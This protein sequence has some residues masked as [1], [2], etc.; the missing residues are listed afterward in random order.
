M[1]VIDV[2]DEGLRGKPLLLLLV[3]EEPVNVDAHFSN[4]A[5]ASLVHVK[6]LRLG[7]VFCALDFVKL[8]SVLLVRSLVPLT[9]VVCE[10]VFQK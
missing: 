3:G 5:F 8:L 10:A 7:E 4:H 1:V 9:H 2:D 6:S